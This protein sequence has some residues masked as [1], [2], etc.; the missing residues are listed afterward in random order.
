MIEGTRDDRLHALWVL[1]A[2][3]GMREAEMLALTWD[4][5]D[6]AHVTIRHTLH[7]IDGEWKLRQPKTEK[8]RRTIPLPP[9]TVAALREHRV[10]QMEEQAAAGA[11]GRSGLVFT[12]PRGQPIHG[13]NLSKELHAVLK[14]LKLPKVNPH[15]LR[16]SAATV[17]YA[18]GV[19]LGV[20]SRML[21]HS[22]IRLTADLYTHRVEDLE[23]DAAD[24]MQGAVG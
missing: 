10:R 7:R 11:L 3:T 13:S 24:K 21:G 5:I 16:H 8:S 15:D 19:P 22:T 23:K 1:A 12:T 2:T 14:R 18:A 6:E 9:V 17:L 20:I 4:D